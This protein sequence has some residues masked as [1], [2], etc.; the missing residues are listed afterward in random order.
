[1]ARHLA[2]REMQGRMPCDQMLHDEP[3]NAAVCKD[4]A[5]FLQAVLQC[6][7]DD[8]RCCISSFMLFSP[9]LQALFSLIFG[10]CFQFKSLPMQDGCL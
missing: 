7:E 8:T 2:I 1:M 4:W 5:L 6:P 9:E 3:C 10:T